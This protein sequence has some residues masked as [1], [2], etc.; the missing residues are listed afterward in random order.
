VAISGGGAVLASFA[1]GAPFLVRKAL[2]KGEVY[3]CATSPDPNWSSLADGSVLVPMLQRLITSGAKR[4]NAGVMLECGDSATRETGRWTRIDANGPGNPRL[5]AG[6]YRAENRFVAV[7]R[8]AAENDQLT[9]SPDRA[10]Q[11][12]RDVPFQ[13]LQERGQPGDRLQGEIWRVFVTLMLLFL[14]LEGVLIL[15]PKAATQAER[16]PIRPRE[17]AEV[18]A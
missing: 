15:P 16:P 5:Q 9:V 12:F 17:P 11:L 4:L 8:P 1:D 3:F 7:N 6:V 2:G 10:R 13:L 14:V 18:A